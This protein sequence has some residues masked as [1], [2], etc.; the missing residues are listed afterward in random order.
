MPEHVE[1]GSFQG[2]CG[3]RKRT[4]EL[5]KGKKIEDSKWTLNCFDCGAEGLLNAITRDRNIQEVC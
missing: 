1:E 3:G 5:W 2:H 4:S